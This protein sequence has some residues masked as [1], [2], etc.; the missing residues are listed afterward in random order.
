MLSALYVPAVIIFLY[1]WST[2]SADS[3]EE[4]EVTLIIEVR[5]CSL[6]PGLIRSGEYP[7]KKSLLKTKFEFFSRMG[8][9]ISSVAPG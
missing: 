9:Q 2:I 7:Q 6:S 4:P 5:R 8:T 1:S 3:N